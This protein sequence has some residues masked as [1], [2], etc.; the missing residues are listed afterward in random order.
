MYIY[1]YKL[2]GHRDA[3]LCESHDKPVVNEPQRL[4]D[5]Y[6]ILNVNLPSFICVKLE[7]L[8]SPKGYRQTE[9]YE[10]SGRNGV[11]C[12][13]CCIYVAEM[14]FSKIR[15]LTV[16]VESQSLR[17]Q[18]AE[19]CICVCVSLLN[20]NDPSYILHDFFCVF[21]FLFVN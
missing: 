20:R 14:L 8:G 17:N 3:K 15:N 12:N 13:S 7:Y 1:I 16:G 11:G 2:N 19:Y 18:F 5:R 6:I 10:C 4:L 9:G 21:L